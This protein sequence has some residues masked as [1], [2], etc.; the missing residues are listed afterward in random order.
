MGAERNRRAPVPS[1]TRVF[2]QPFRGSDALAAGLLTRGRL[3]GPAFRRLFD[4]VYVAADVPVDLALRSRAAHLLVAGRGVLAGYSAAEVLGASCG[5]QDAPAEV[6]LPGGCLLRQPGLLVHRGLLL[7]DEATTVAAIGVT[8]RARTAYDLARRAP[9]LVEA[10][11][12]VDALAAAPTRPRSGTVRVDPAD[13]APA[14]QPA[15]GRPQQPAPARRRRAGR[16]A[17][18]VA[19][20]DTDAARARPPRPPA[21]G[22]AAR[23][24][25]RRALPLPGSR[26]PRVPGGHRVRRRRAPH[27]GTRPAGPGA[28]APA[29]DSRLDARPPACRASSCSAPASSRYRC[30]ANWTAPPSASACRRSPWRVARWR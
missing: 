30:T 18:R 25:R 4:D 11:V 21:A 10:V 27:A 7:P 14:A 3:R 26:L 20:G 16:P 24:A 8:T 6:A 1:V 12:A 19:D 13:A 29:L 22:V 17:G 2:E 28:P 15:P 23:G 5:P 9:S